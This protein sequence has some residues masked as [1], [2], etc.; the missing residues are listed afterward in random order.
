MTE[1]LRWEDSTPLVH[2]ETHKIM[3]IQVL[4]SRNLSRSYSDD[5]DDDET[6]D[7]R[8]EADIK[9]TKKSIE[10]YNQEGELWTIVGVQSIQIV[11]PRHERLDWCN[12]M[13][14]ETL[15][16]SNTR[17][18][19]KPRRDQSAMESIQWITIFSLNVNLTLDTW[20]TNNES[21]ILKKKTNQCMSRSG[22]LSCSRR[23]RRTD[24]Y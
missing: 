7:M 13:G 5:D 1:L 4:N 10:L 18:R 3:W 11:S 6:P 12:F 17:L 21:Y 24:L 8:H 19:L 2:S 22:G 14:T 20:A 16:N 9:A 15:L 23:L